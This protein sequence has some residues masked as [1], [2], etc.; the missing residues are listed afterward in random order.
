MSAAPWLNWLTT[1]KI[2]SSSALDGLR[3]RS[4]RPRCRC[5]AARSLSGTSAYAASC[6]RSCGKRYSSSTCSSR[7]SS[8]AARSAPSGERPETLASVSASMLAPRQ[9][10][11]LRSSCVSAGRACSLPT[12]RSTTLS[13][14]RCARMRASSHR[15]RLVVRS[16]KISPCRCSAVRNWMTKNGLPPVFSRTRRASG[17]ASAREQWTVSATSSPTWAS[18]S[19]PSTR[20]R[21]VAPSARASS[22]AR[23]SGCAGPTSLS[24]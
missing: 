24:R 4:S 13:V 18:G 14:Y 7:S 11:S 6:T 9:A 1:S 8:S 3:S 23:T 15:Q 16:K 10:A 19:G 22:S 17:S 2:L 21:I 12:I 5:I 20:S